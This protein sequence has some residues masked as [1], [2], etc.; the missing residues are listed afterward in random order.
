MPRGKRV[1][2]TDYEQSQVYSAAVEMLKQRKVQLPISNSAGRVAFLKVMRECQVVLPDNRR[3][4][5]INSLENISGDL[6]TRFITNNVLTK[7]FK[8]L[9]KGSDKKLKEQAPDPQALRI[10]ELEAEVAGNKQYIQ[11]R[12]D[13]ITELEA[14]IVELQSQPTPMQLIQ[15]FVADTLAM[16]LTQANRHPL[17]DYKGTPGGASTGGKSQSH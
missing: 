15:K 3:R 9:K 11:E 13:R 4:P 8:N 5:H 16:A 7:D 14:R 2:W 12:E 10:Q 6:A 1:D 17:S